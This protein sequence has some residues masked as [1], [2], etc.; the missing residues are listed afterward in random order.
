MK[1]IALG[2][3]LTLLPLSSV[4]AK[5]TYIVKLKDNAPESMAALLS[6]DQTTA[7]NIPVRFG[8]FLKLESDA[9]VA[10]MI[11]LPES[12]SEIEY[13]EPSQTY[14]PIDFVE[15]ESFDALASDRYGEQWGLKNTGRNSGSWWSRGK[16]GEDINAEKAWSVTKGDRTLRVAVIDTGVDYNHPDLKDQM[17]TNELEANGQ[18][19]VDDDGNGYVDDIHGYDFQNKDG[20]PMDD[21]NHGT[22]S[23]GVIGASHNGSGV[24][25]VMADVELVAIKFLSARGGTTEDAILS[26]QYAIDVNVNIMSNSW[27]GGG[28]SQA[29]LDAIEAANQAGIVFVAAAGNSNA[30][31][32]TRDNYPSN[33]DTDNMIA[34]GSMTGKGT[35]S[36]FSNYGKTTVDTFAPGS[37]ILSTVRNGGYSKMSGTSMACPH[38]AGVAGLL[39]SIEPN[40]TPKEVRDRMVRTAKDNGSLSGYGQS[41]RIDA[42]N[43]LTKK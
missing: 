19:G 17:W 24:R 4:F 28:F 5:Q 31:N 20:D 38:V 43:M 33:Y 13:I 21:H 25:G 30:N 36:G 27:G 39:L 16:A 32:D 15:G 14:Y 2:A 22:H 42:Y 34:V 18:P 26:V 40:L 12:V 35:R 6:N 3:V 8:R 9:P 1:K 11:Q 41:G 10:E 7:K 23:A 29:L 37:D